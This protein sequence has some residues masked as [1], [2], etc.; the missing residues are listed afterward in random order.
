[1]KTKYDDDL[2]YDKLANLPIIKHNYTTKPLACPANFLV[3]RL[4]PPPAMQKQVGLASRQHGIA[5]FTKP[6]YRTM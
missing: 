2:N 1:M 6:L 4:N 3:W 5:F